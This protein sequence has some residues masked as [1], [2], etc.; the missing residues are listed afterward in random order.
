MFFIFSELKWEYPNKNFMCS[1][2]SIYAVDIHENEIV[3]IKN[4]VNPCTHFAETYF[5]FV[6]RNI[7]NQNTKY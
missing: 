2:Y 5:T 3:R 7:E 4:W 1:N 6:A